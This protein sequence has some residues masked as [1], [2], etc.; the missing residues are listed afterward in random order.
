MAFKIQKQLIPT[1]TFSEDPS[2]AKRQIWVYKLNSGDTV[3]SFETEAAANTKRDE[4][5][6]ADPTNRVYQVVEE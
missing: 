6:A 5:I 1:D 4:L 2:W 3:E